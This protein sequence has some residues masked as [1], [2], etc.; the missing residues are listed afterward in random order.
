MEPTWAYLEATWSQLGLKLGPNCLY[1]AIL[2]DLEAILRPCEACEARDPKF[3][4]KVIVF[5]SKNDKNLPQK[6]QKY[7]TIVGPNAF[8]CF[9]KKDLKNLDF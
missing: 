3:Y 8:S 7:I 9:S 1:K 4:Q 5:Y 6:Y 2:G